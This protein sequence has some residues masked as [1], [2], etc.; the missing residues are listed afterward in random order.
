MRKMSPPRAW[1]TPEGDLSGPSQ[2]ADRGDQA[3]REN[4]CGSGNHSSIRSDSIGR[5]SG[6]VYMTIRPTLQSPLW[7]PGGLMSISRRNIPTKTSTSD[8]WK[9][10][11]SKWSLLTV[12]RASNASSP[13]RTVGNTLVT[14]PFKEK[15]FGSIDTKESQYVEAGSRYSKPGAATISRIAKYPATA[16]ADTPACG[17]MDRSLPRIK[18]R[19]KIITN[20][21]GIFSLKP[22]EN[23]RRTENSRGRSM[24]N[25]NRLMIRSAIGSTPV[26]S[27]NLAKNNDNNATISDALV[28]AP[29]FFWQI[30]KI[31]PAVARRLSHDTAAKASVA[32]R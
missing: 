15:R 27:R 28:L 8:L 29:S 5:Y 17:R 16:T 18:R 20:R 9:S 32:R 21:S 3:I 1:Q 25:S 7:A 11:V 26:S 13:M 23:S 4:L 30:R 24:R 22:T 19:P 14:A 10:A 12:R 6:Y 2:Q 31:T